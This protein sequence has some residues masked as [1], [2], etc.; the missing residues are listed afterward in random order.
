MQQFPYPRKSSTVYTPN[1]TSAYQQRR[2]LKRYAPLLLAFIGL[3]WLLAYLFGGKSSATYIPPGTPPVVIVTNLD[4]Q[5]PE[6]FREA[7]KENRRAYAA[8]HGYS[9]FFTNSTDYDLIE[10]TPQSC[11]WLWYLSPE[12]LIMN[13]TQSLQTQLLDPPLLKALLI[14]DQPVV[15]PDSVIKT[16]S[17]ISTSSINLILSQDGEGLAGGS[18]LLRT[19]EWAKFF[20]DAWFDPLYRSYNFQKAEGHALEHIVQWHGT[21]LSKLALVPQRKLNSYTKT[22]EDGSSEGL[23]QPSDFI[24]NFHGCQRNPRR[25]CEEEMGPFIAKAKENLNSGVGGK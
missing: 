6:P 4:P 13:P 3:V 21:V 8:R 11:T 24:A 9:Y 14:K 1:H 16:L 18:F 5:L 22:A 19:G 2:L 10:K 23:Y 12:A 15:P 20:L 25:N 7:V 17:H